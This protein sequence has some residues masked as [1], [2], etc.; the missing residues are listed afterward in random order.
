[1]DE[2]EEGTYWIPIIL[3]PPR[4]LL[5]YKGRPNKV[6]RDTQC[7]H[8]ELRFLRAAS[9]RRQGVQ[10]VRDLITLS[11]DIFTRHIKYTDIADI[12]GQQYLKERLE[13][14]RKRLVTTNSR[15]HPDI[16]PAV[17]GALK[18]Q[19]MDR[20]QKVKDL[21]P[22]RIVNEIS[23]PFEIPTKLTWKTS[24]KVVSSQSIGHHV[25]VNP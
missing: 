11:S 12:Y 3:N 13:E 7:V 9:V 23:A 14:Q 21:F 18:R 25:V 6:T 17:L 20:A 8:L 19:G 22:R 2:W 5:V 16:R 24:T 10:R 1:M 15:Y 4:N